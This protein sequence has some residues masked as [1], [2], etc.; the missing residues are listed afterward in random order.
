MRMGK[1][2]HEW[3]KSL[4]KEFVST[5]R[6]CIAR[7]ALTRGSLS[8]SALNWDSF[9]QINHT[10]S[11]VVPDELKVTAQKQSGRCWIFAA[12]NLLRRKIAHRYKLDDFEFS[13]NT[14]FFWDK[15]EKAK[16]FLQSIIDTAKEPV[17]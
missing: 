9:R 3:V 12:L 8:Q 7:N 4:K 5:P 1:I 17:D 14:L 10:F 15:L 16:Y 13:Q 6:Y 11:H 2:S